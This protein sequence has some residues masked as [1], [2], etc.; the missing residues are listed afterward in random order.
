MGGADVNEK[1]ANIIGNGKSLISDC[2][3]KRNVPSSACTRVIF[4]VVPLSD[5]NY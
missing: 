5:N 3:T 4:I 2:R 1:F